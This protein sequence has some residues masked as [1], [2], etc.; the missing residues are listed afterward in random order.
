MQPMIFLAAV[1][2]TG[3]F[4]V[5]ALGKSPFF[6][7]DR[8]GAAIIGAA[9]TIASGILTFDQAT[10]FIDF[11]TIALLFSMMILTAYLKLSGFFQWVGN[12][13]LTRLRTK[14]QLLGAVVAA[15]GMLSAL[16]VND[17]ICL[18]F[19]PIVLII[20]QRAQLPPV[21]YLIGVATASNVGS[22]ATLIGNPQNMLIGS[23]SRLSFV[24]YLIVAAPLALVGLAINYY[25]IRFFYRDALTGPLTAGQLTGV[26]YHR[27]LVRKSLWVTAFILTGFV[28]GCE[29]V[30]VAG[31]GAAYLL[32]TRRLKPNKVYASIDFN[33]LVIFTGLFIVIGGVEKSGLMGWLMERLSFIDFSIFPLFA[34]L[35]LVL[36]NIF[37]NVPAVLLLK[38]FIPATDI[39]GVWWSG[40]AIFSTF[41]GNLT[42]TGSIANLIVVEIAKREHVSI[43]FVEYMRIGLPLTLLIS[44]IGLVYFQLFYL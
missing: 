4:V 11:R 29:P 7:V 1:I 3:T 20:C 8:A 36:S 28:T 6:R 33:L 30:V 9:L 43:G 5:F 35:T 38:F 31:L 40:M 14:N 39:S 10:Q 42:I 18:L 15:S 37:S 13:M 21:P 19:T 34:V 24:Q 32:I 44:A 12:L 22:A 26:V 17:I 41:A 2:L 25:L 27:H 23:L 16:F